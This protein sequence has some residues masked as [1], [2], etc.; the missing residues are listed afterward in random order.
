MLWALLAWG[1]RHFAPEGPSVVIVDAATGAVADP[2]LVDRASGRPM[3][4]P[5][6]RSAAGPA[7]DE[8][9]IQRHGMVARVVGDAHLA[10]AT[11]RTIRPAGGTHV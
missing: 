10:T 4:A 9:T 5:A 6:F 11:G 8:Q 3:R 2:V 7:A 1:N